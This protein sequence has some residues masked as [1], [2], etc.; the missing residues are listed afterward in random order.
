[1]KNIDKELYSR[2]FKIYGASQ[3][4]VV[5]L[6]EMAELQKELCKHLRGFC[7]KTDIAE[8]VADVQIMLEQI[9]LYFNISEEIKEYRQKKLIRLEKRLNAIEAGDR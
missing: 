9:E 3:Q 7:P 4:L 1:M 2:A 8:E 5:A 6:E